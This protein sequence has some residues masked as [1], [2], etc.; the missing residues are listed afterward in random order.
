MPSS[1]TLFVAFSFL[2]HGA[3]AIGIG[4]ME[5]PKL[6]A[7]TAIEMSETKK[8]KPKAP[9]PAK[10]E[11]ERPKPQHEARPRARAAAAP[12][13]EPAA[14]AP[15]PMSALPDFGLSL[16]GGIEGDGIALPAATAA[17]QAA[18]ATA[19]KATATRRVAT[20]APAAPPSDG[21]AEDPSKPK[22]ISV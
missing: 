11:P 6:H 18:P 9:A 22:P 10:V 19:A 16:S 15:T 17:G 12:A 2:V 4:E 7:A 20:A 21:C 1:K 13:A 5:I 3:F 14:A 8:A